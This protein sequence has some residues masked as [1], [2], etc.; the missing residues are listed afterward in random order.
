MKKYRRLEVSKLLWGGQ[1]KLFSQAAD[2]GKNKLVLLSLSSK[3]CKV[4]GLSGRGED[5]AKVEGLMG[6]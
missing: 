3:I 5:R 4:L 2:T 6:G 1:V